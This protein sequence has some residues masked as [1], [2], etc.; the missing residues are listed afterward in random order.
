MHCIVRRVFVR[1]YSRLY[2]IINVCNELVDTV[3][4]LCN[5]TVSIRLSVCLSHLSTVAAACGGFAAVGP[6]DKGY[7]SV[8]AR[9]ALS[10]NC[11][12]CHVVS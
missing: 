8:A 4:G 1:A 11:E 2:F 6:A 10:S 12:Q 3:E 7:P 5:G 9:P